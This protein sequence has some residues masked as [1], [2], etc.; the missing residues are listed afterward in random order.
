MKDQE[1]RTENL[2]HQSIMDLIM[3]ELNKIDKKYLELNYGFSKAECTSAL[4]DSIVK[5]C[6]N[7]G[8]RIV[9]EE[10]F[11]LPEFIRTNKRKYGCIVDFYIINP[12]GKDIIIEL[13]SSLNKWSY[14]K[15]EYFSEDYNAVWIVWKRGRGN[16]NYSNFFE[17][18]RNKESDFSNENVSFFKHILDLSNKP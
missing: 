18:S 15:L 6:E 8:L 3:E 1:R 4:S 7:L 5:T 16:L 10:K 17:K 2:T 13:D 11:K 12:N 9:R 14:Q